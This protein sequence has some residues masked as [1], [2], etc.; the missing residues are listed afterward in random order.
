MEVQQQE[1]LTQAKVIG[2]V[3]LNFIQIINPA[4]FGMAGLSLN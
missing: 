2:K 1:I 4:V 3:G